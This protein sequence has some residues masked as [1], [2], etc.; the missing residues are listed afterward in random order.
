LFLGNVKDEIHRLGVF[1]G[2]T[3]FFV[4]KVKDK[5]MFGDPLSETESTKWMTPEE[6][7]KTGRTIH[8]PV[9]S[10]A[11]RYID[12]KEGIKKNE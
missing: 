9:I 11:V 7:D 10:A 3:T 4:I 5:D 6:F 1:L 2:Y 12:K 8:K